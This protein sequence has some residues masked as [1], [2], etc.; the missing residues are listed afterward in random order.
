[1]PNP[2]PCLP[3]ACPA[4]CGRFDRLHK[5]EMPSH[6]AQLTSGPAR[7]GADALVG[8]GAPMR[9]AKPLATLGALYLELLELIEQANA[10]PAATAELGDGLR[11][12]VGCGGLEK[13]ESAHVECARPSSCPHGASDI[14]AIVTFPRSGTGWIQ[15]TYSRVTGLQYESVY[16]P[17]E[18]STRKPT[19]YGTYAIDG[20]GRAPVGNEPIFVKTHHPDWSC[21]PPIFGRHHCIVARAVHVVRNPLDQ[22]LS[23]WSKNDARKSELSTVSNKSARLSPELH[24]RWVTDAPGWART[25][26]RWHC[27]A[28]VSYRERP[29]LLLRYDD[30]VADPEG[31]FRRVFGF[32]LGSSAPAPTAEQLRAIISVRHALPTTHLRGAMP[33]YATD[34]RLVTPAVVDSIADAMRD[35]LSDGAWAA[36][37]AATDDTHLLGG[38]GPIFSA[39]ALRHPHKNRTNAYGTIPSALLD[40]R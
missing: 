28:A 17:V 29:T 14:V 10:L 3:P 18:G 9:L 33:V 26:V 20:T 2:F 38:T 1:M 11:G 27:R 35:A 21:P 25:Y 37:L 5:H 16:N 7:L 40:H 24:A 15:G 12:K 6:M 39:E 31:E 32:V 19:A 4:A 34:E 36:A 30:L 8:Y 23:I 22:I 13:S